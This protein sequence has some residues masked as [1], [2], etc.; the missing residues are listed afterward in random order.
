MRR[1]ALLGSTGSIGRTCLNAIKTH[2][3][4]LSIGGLACHREKTLLEQQGNEFHTD[5]LTL[6]ERDGFPAIATM[7]EK[8]DAEIVLNGISGFDGL[9]ASVMVLEQGKDLALANKES[10]VC[11]SSFLFDL[12][13]RHHA[14]IIPVDSEHSAIWEL[15]KGKEKDQVESLVI[16]ASGG[17]FLHRTKAQME[18]V[19]VEQALHHPTWKMGK[20][21]TIDSATLANKAMEV[22][23][24]A[25]LFGF[26]A[27]HIE[28][29]VHRESIV[30]S[31]IRMRNGAVYAQ[32]GNPDM[33]I[34][35][36]ASLLPS[37]TAPLVAP[38]DFTN[39]DLHFEKPDTDTFPLLALAFRILDKKGDSSIALNAADEVCVDAFLK[40]RI[41]FLDIARIVTKVVE[42]S[43]GKAPENIQE[44][45]VSDQEYRRIA[46]SLLP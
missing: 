40:R 45:I 18:E 11:G 17:P 13:K 37:N 33:S 26:D 21:I 3:L 20:K 22:L 25:G 42:E 35:I 2:G 7:L 8:S 23:E 28:V 9:K 43:N 4:P 39:L 38:L 41:G 10:I 27:S 6:V 29:V 1:I 30:H 14:S 24:A 16:T 31:M 5:N 34:P 46:C 32:M 12:A 15:L 19:T 36:I 44:A